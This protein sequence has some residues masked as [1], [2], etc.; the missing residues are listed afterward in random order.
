[1]FHLFRRS[2]AYVS[3]QQARSAGSG[4]LFNG[5]LCVLFSVAIFTNPDLLA[6]LVATFLLIIGVSLLTTWWKMRNWTR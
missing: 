4:L 2:I 5:L 1:M 3:Q 6:F